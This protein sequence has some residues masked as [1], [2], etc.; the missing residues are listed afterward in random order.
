MT[1]DEI[2][3]ILVEYQIRHKIIINGKNYPLSGSTLTGDKYP[4]APFLHSRDANE[5]IND[6]F[7][8][9]IRYEYTYATIML[10]SAWNFQRSYISQIKITDSFG[11]IIY[12]AIF[13]LEMLINISLPLPVH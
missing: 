4:A 2:E 5:T 8:N 10:N 3:E 11:K 7:G 6:R 12:V 9:T 13:L 1:A